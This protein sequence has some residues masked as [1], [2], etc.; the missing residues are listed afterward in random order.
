M[1][2]NAKTHQGYY[3]VQNV[4]KYIGDPNLVIFRSSYEYVFCRWCDFSPSILHWSSEPIRIPYYDRV[5]KLEEYKKQG[6]DPNNPKNWIV[7]YYNTDFWIEI[8]QGEGKTQKMFVEIKPS[9]KLKKP[10]LPPDNAPLKDV[11]RFNNLAK[12]YLINEAKFAAL[13]AWAEKSGAIFKVFT[14]ETLQRIAAK[15]WEESLDKTKW[16]H[17]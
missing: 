11:R 1:S 3:K 5:S 13:N 17:Q 7:K 14:E 6:I 2:E 9:N 15:F 16:N 10:A 12:E 8:D 4:S